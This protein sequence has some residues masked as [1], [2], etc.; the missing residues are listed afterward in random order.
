MTIAALARACG[1]DFGTSNS[2]VGCVSA[3]GAVLLPLEDD[4]PLL[5]S[6]VFFD[7]L[8]LRSS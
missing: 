3:D 5:P 2:A 1:V 4:A 8:M 7:Y 6:V